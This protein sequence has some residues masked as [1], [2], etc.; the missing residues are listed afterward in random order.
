[1]PI[2]P[3]NSKIIIAKHQMLRNTE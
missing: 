1:M 2:Q 3:I